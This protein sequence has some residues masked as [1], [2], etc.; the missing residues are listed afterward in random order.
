MISLA[1]A[2]EF[3]LYNPETGIVTWRKDK[4][5][6]KKGSSPKKANNEGYYVLRFKGKNYLLHRVAWLLHYGDFPCENL[7]HRNRIRTDNRIKNLREASHSVNSKNRGKQTNNTSGVTGV[8][9]KKDR[10]K[11]NASI[12]VDGSLINLGHFSKFSEAVDARKL[13]EATYGFIQK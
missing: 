12:T 11:W 8:Y 4:G 2:N 6:A 7:D 3:L 5:R 1:E 10:L 13:A 9:W